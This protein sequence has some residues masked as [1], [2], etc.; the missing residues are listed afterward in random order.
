MRSTSV[1]FLN[2]LGLRLAGRLDVPDDPRGGPGAI[3]CH[4]FTC[5]K[6]FKAAFHVARALTLEGFSVL[7][8]DFPGLGE[9][10]GDF[11][12]VT[13]SANV[14]D[15]LSAAAFLSAR[16]VGPSLLIGHSMGGAAAILAASRISSVRAVAV[17]GA[18]AE[19]R[20]LSA[21]LALARQ[22]A[23]VDGA[24]EALI[25]GRSV[26]LRRRFF[27]DLER[28]SL[29]EAIRTLPVPLLILHS[30]D[31]E[32]SPFE[33]AGRILREAGPSGS[34][35]SLIGCDHLLSRSQDASYAGR[36]I[37]AW[38]SPFVGGQGLP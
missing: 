17:L 24:G 11:A 5:N 13:L 15:V 36:L 8:F 7:R 30:P 34:F 29:A 10:E 33:N 32:I 35:I 23:E 16:G 26:R 2:A 6:N 22:K 14:D 12:E 18:P 3:F 28:T 31:D 37:A 27:E 1:S 25:A 38:C 19:P 4:C 9:S 21:P 20:E